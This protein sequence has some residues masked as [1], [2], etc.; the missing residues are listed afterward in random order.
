M[1]P[2]R[3]RILLPAAMLGLAA[4]ADPQPRE[5]SVPEALPPADVPERPA[6]PPG[7]VSQYTELSDCRVVRVDPELAGAA[8]SEC[9]GPGGYRL[10]LRDSDGR[11]DL[12]LLPPG[13]GE[14]P[15]GLA[16]ISRG[17]FSGLGPRIEW[18]GRMA[19]GGFRPDA[20]IL[21]YGWVVEPTPDMRETEHL[22]AVA[23]GPPPCILAVLPPGDGRNEAARAAA[24]RPVCPAG[25]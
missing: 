12:D 9:D 14:V 10:R 13:G 16:D 21:R 1:R 3:M 11:H 15:L 19:D 17:A 18:R 8:D 4:C 25:G 20:M 23:L 22:V 2:W 5:E 7:R 24:D 6:P